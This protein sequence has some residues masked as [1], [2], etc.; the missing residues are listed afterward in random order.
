MIN[1]QNCKANGIRHLGY[2]GIM[3]KLMKG[4][5]IKMFGKELV[6]ELKKHKLFEFYWND[7]MHCKKSFVKSRLRKI[8]DMYSGG[9]NL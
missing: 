3:S 1:I 8:K 9:K 4:Q 5:Y 2:V 7:E 6:G